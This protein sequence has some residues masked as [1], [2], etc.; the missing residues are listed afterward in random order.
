MHRSYR[1]CASPGTITVEHFGRW[2]Q[3]NIYHPVPAA[4]DL[5]GAQATTFPSLESATVIGWPTGIK[6][7]LVFFCLSRSRK[8]RCNGE[9]AASTGYGAAGAVAQS[10][11][12]R[13]IGRRFSHGLF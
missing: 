11:F 7:L 1:S 6:P 13:G 2:P 8:A 5:I 3:D 12:R 4:W 9:A 10:V